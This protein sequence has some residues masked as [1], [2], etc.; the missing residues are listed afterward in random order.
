M[1]RFAQGGVLRF[2]FGVPQAQRL[3]VVGV[4]GDGGARLPLLGSVVGALGPVRLLEAL[5]AERELG[6]TWVL[7]LTTTDPGIAEDWLAWSTVGM[8]GLVFKRLAQS[9]V[10]GRRGWTKYRTRASTEVVVGAVSGSLSAPATVL[11]GRLDAVG[12]LHYVGRTS[13]LS[14]EAGQRLAAQLTAARDG[15]PWAGRTFSAGWGSGDELPVQLVEPV[16]VAEVSG[17][18]LLDP[19]GRW[20]HS[21]RWLRLRTEAVPG[22]VPRIGEGNDPASG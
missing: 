21:V 20:R 12:A 3:D 5:F 6:G 18:V 19:T 15:H 22:D 8:E 1:E 17:D 10:S 11:L 13:V 4:G 16:L 7:C 2:E 14:H 9:Y